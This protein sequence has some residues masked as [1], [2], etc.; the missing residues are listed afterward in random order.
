MKTSPVEKSTPP[1]SC[2]EPRIE[3]IRF[4]VDKKA[5]PQSISEEELAAIAVR[6]S[7]QESA[8]TESEWAI[9]G[10]I[11]SIGRYK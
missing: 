3:G 5:S 1:T 10:R 8:D 9:C 4:V 2:E 11:E 7:L 6:L